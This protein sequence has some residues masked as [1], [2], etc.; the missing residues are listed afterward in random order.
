MPSLAKEGLDAATLVGTARRM[1]EI[2]KLLEAGTANFLARHATL[3]D[4]GYAVLDR[5]R[6]LYL[7]REIVSRVLASLLICIGGN[8]YP[9]RQARLARLT[10]SLLAEDRPRARTLGGCRV[11]CHGDRLL[12]VREAG[13]CEIIETPEGSGVL[14]DNRYRIKVKRPRSGQPRLC[15]IRALGE[16]GWASIRRAD[17]SPRAFQIPPAARTA[18][19]AL[20]IGDRV[21]AVPHLGFARETKN[22]AGILRANVRF[23]PAKSASSVVFPVA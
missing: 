7:D 16:A 11:L 14:W 9:P 12:I 2:R 22:A 4:E 5:D 17:L 23:M 13:R 21:M 18:V 1:G 6:F 19:P 3:Y 10:E 8:V 15:R 20:Y